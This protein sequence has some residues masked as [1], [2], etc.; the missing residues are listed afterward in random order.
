MFISFRDEPVI[1][2]ALEPAVPQPTCGREGEQ[3]VKKTVDPE[4]PVLPIESAAG[5]DSGESD[6]GGAGV[7]QGLGVG[8]HEIGEEQ[9]R[10]VLERVGKDRPA[11]AEMAD[12]QEEQA[13]IKEEKGPT[14]VLSGR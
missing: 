14:N 11:L 7:R 2:F 6:A 3:N 12:A 4:K 9:Q 13:E 8:D 1:A 10:A 5:D